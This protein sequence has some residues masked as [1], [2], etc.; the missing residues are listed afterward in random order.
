MS[1]S[2]KDCLGYEMGNSPWNPYR[3]LQ[4]ERQIC[5]YWVL[6]LQFHLSALHAAMQNDAWPCLVCLNLF[7]ITSHNLPVVAWVYPLME[8]CWAW[9]DKQNRPKK[10]NPQKS[11]FVRGRFLKV[12]VNNNNRSQVNQK[13]VQRITKAIFEIKSLWIYLVN[14]YMSTNI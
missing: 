2:K 4:K 8:E 9:C 7:L 1:L 10:Q 13:L 12:H 5:D 11:I 6:K 14:R 3:S